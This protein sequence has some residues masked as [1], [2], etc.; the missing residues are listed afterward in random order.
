MINVDFNIYTEKVNNYL[1]T[2]FE[3]DGKTD[4]FAAMNYSLMVGGK[5]I[6]PMLTLMCCTAMGGREEDALPLAAAIEM[7]HTYSLIHD[8]LPAMD[9]DDLRRGKPTCHKKY[10]EATAILAGDGLLTDAFAQI[11]GSALSDRQKVAATMLLSRAAGPYGMVLG[12]ALDMNLKDKSADGILDMYSKK[13]GALLRAAAGLGAIAAGGRGDE[14]DEYTA[15]IG[16]AF[17]IKDDI[18]DMEGNEEELGKPIGSDNKN[19]K[20][21]I[22]SAIGIERAKELLAEYTESAIS[23]A[24]VLPNSEAFIELAGKLIKRNK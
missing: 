17:Q 22:V 18:L 8:D 7:V 11:T 13:T 14:F 20:N 1:K 10:D 15:N 23:A 5:R 3:D 21:T 16:A 9:D 12:Q 24:G 4:L 6:R 2:I 19:D